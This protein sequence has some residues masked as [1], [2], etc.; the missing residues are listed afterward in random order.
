MKKIFK[1]ILIAGLSL[2]LVSCDKFFDSMEG[3]LSKVASD[4]M[5]SSVAGLQA[6][7]ADLYATL[8][9]MGMSS[10]DLNTMFASS[11]RSAPDY[12]V[13]GV[14]GKWNYGDIR[15]VHKFI[16][17]LDVAV[18]KG[19]IDDETKNTYMGEALFI[20][21]SIYFANV[22]VH[23]G[24]PIVEEALDDKYDGGDNAG[25]Y[26]PR[27]KEKETWDWVID[28]F[29]RA[30]DLLP[31]NQ[32]QE[33]R[34]T[35]YAALAMK[36]RV[37]LWAA[38]V[39][40]YWDRAPLNSAYIARQK[41]L[42]YMAA[43]YANA[44]YKIAVDASEAVIK[45]GKYYLAGENPANIGAAKTALIELFQ[46][47][48]SKEGILGRSY[49]TGSTD[50]GNGNQGWPAHQVVTGYQVG[51]YSVTLNMADEYD[52]Y[53]GA[54][55]RKHLPGTIK[56]LVTGDESYYL[57]EPAQQMA[58]GVLPVSSLK[59]YD[60]VDEP[61]LLK[62]AR[63]QAW[64]C[65][66]GTTFRRTTI[67]AEGGMVM[68]D[69]TVSVYPNNNNG[70]EKNGVTYY[71][72]GGKLNENSFYYR[73]NIDTNDSNRSFFC[74]TIRKGQDENGYTANPQT[75]W[76]NIR[77]SEMLL[78]YA[79][80]TVENTANHGNVADAKKYLNDV[81]HRAG[82]KDDVDLTLDNV[83]HEWKVE[84]A[85]ENKWPMVL[86]RRRAYYNPSSTPTV[87]EGSIGK[88]LT[89][90]PMVD[91][92]GAKAQWVFLR[93]VPYHTQQSTGYYSTLQVYA[94]NYYSSIPNYVYNRIEQNNTLTE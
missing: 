3:D 51:T 17:A 45:S 88:K 64:V 22:R 7:L 54:D 21:A 63:F 5:S 19:I 62:D 59:H 18:K 38:S 29:Q 68:P 53:D 49:K 23:G 24:I 2:G 28:Q 34:V 31:V 30:A 25:L 35:K 27:K 4:D 66:P 10:G 86:Y 20:R 36:A 11:S 41:E 43:S 79:E 39:S 60:S 73:L 44:Y 40:K 58:Y 47:Y 74:F 84:F 89:L 65:Y 69:G 92:S 52:Y 81:R 77:F 57:T 1:Y 78:T 67:N 13:N 32:A 37:A 93:A 82:F 6:M 50:N 76:Y 91:L 61:F 9:D 26:F 14:G 85:F 48:D 16:E 33:M 15:S 71:P 90:I 72:Y 8:P 83:L 70:V 55:S 87:E 94:D 75:P 12:N 42:T 56:T 80:A 46:K